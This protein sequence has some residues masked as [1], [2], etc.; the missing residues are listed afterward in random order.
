MEIY[1]KFA[2]IY[3]S[4][5]TEVPYDEWLEIILEILKENEINDGI[6]ADIACGSG[7]M[8]IRMADKGY[9]MIGLDMSPAMLERAKDKSTGRRQERGPDRGQQRA[10]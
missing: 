7:E 10:V 9:D 4:I 6:V 5:M 2:N 3:D 1:G 8:T